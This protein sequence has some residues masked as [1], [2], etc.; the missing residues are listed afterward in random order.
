MKRRSSLAAA[1][2]I[3]AAFGTRVGAA[4]VANS[5]N[6]GL[7]VGGRIQLIGLAQRVND[8]IRDQTRMYMFIHQARLNLDG[9]F[10]GFKYLVTLGFAGE[11]EARAPSPGVSLG[12]LDM[13]VDV[14]IRPLGNTYLR[15]GQFKIPYSLERLE[16]PGTLAFSD[17]SI[18]N[19]AFRMGRDYGLAL[20]SNVGV[21][22]GAVGVF[23]GG[24]RDVPERFLPLVLGTPMLVARA[25]LDNGVFENAFAQ[26]PAQSVQGP[27]A[28]AFINALYLKDSQIGHSTVLNV[29]LGERSLLVNPNWNPYM[30]ATPFSRGDFW[31]IG[32]DV[33]GR[34]P[35]GSGAIVAEAEVN[36]GRY[37]N[38]Y[39]AVAA[40]GGRAQL[41]YEWKPIEATVRYAV[42]RP[43]Q[44]MTSGGVA[45]TGG[46]LINEITPALAYTYSRN[47]RIVADLPVLVNVPVVTENNLGDYVLMDHPDQT[48][49]LKTA[50]GATAPAGTVERKNVVS[51]RLMFQGTF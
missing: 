42:I 47:V 37:A 3:V 9:H 34:L 48:S 1:A 49:L 21:V 7:D 22:K 16:D 25:G 24:G 29:H 45:I 28:A 12:L 46:K 27:K 11:D 20:Y 44:N 33:A 39:G 6:F 50:A 2:M 14:P 31:E 5:E 15:V 43:D 18:Q 40:N 17:R 30:A 32:A 23:S 13:Y 51:A 26:K 38:D 19:V 36:R 4:E 8:P 35:A 10:D 41:G